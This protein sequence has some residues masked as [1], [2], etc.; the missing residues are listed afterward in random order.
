MRLPTRTVPPFS[1]R[2]PPID[3]WCATPCTPGDVC[4]NWLHTTTLESC[5]ARIR[6]QGCNLPSGQQYREMKASASRP[7]NWRA[8][9]RAPSLIGLRIANHQGREVSPAILDSRRGESVRFSRPS[10]LTRRADALA[11]TVI[12][13]GS[14]VSHDRGA[15]PKFVPGATS[16]PVREPGC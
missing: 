5:R 15:L 2:K 9:T 7:Q 16:S 6:Q 11:N 14:H 12:S 8:F 10:D 4:D 13:T 1:L 3:L